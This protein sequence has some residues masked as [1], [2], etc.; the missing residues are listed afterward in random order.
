MSRAFLRKLN[1][2][3]KPLEISLTLLYNIRSR[4]EGDPLVKYI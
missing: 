3:S 1:F 4:K 2:F